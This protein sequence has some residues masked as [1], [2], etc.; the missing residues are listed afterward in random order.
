MG[1]TINRGQAPRGMFSDRRLYL[2]ADKATV[3][4]EGDSG[5]AYLLASE[6]AEIS[7]ADVGRLGLSM[8]DGRVVQGAVE[9]EAEPDPVVV[10]E[11]VPEEDDGDG[12]PVPEWP[13]KTPPEDYLER[14][15]DG[16]NAD[17]AR[18]IIAAQDESGPGE[19]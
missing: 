5:A 14:S 10:D 7:A 3:L 2:S 6:G 9:A 18:Q 19:S 1:L 17:L 12:E 11:D 15:P 16:P 13:L 4:E 8:V